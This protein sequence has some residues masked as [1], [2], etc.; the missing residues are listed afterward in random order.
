MK[1]AHIEESKSATGSMVRRASLQAQGWNARCKSLHAAWAMTDPLMLERQGDLVGGDCAFA[2]DH[3]G[4]AAAGEIDD[5][6]GGG[7]G[8]GATVDDEGELVAELFADAEGRG[9]LGVAGEV[10]RGGGDGEAQAGYD[11]AGD[12]GLGNAKGEV[13]GVGGHAKGELAAGLDHDGEGA[14]PELLGEA[15]E[16]GVELAGEF[17]GLGDLGDEEREG[18]VPGAG[19]ELVDAV[20][21]AE[22]DRVDGEAVEGIGR[23]RDDVAAVE[24]GDDVADERGFGLVGMNTECFGRQCGLLLWGATP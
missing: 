6:G 9:A 7:A 10:S 21:G 15:V 22:I 24:A 12:G 14:G 1:R 16:G 3:P 5:G 23:E 4:V 8:G 11:G 18:L 20:D 17:V 2:E 19:L 13:A